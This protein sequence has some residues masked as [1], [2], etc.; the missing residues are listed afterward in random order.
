MAEGVR[1]S[2]LLL[3]LCCSSNAQQSTGIAP[4]PF[5][6]DECD[7]IAEGSICLYNGRKVLMA[8]ATPKGLVGHWNF[9]EAKVLDSSGSGNHAKNAIPAGPGYGGH[10]SSAMFN[11]FDW[12]EIPHSPSFNSPTYSITFW[13]FLYK[14][15]AAA[16][17][18]GSQSCP[19]LHKGASNDEK[20]PSLVIDSATRGLRFVSS[21]SNTQAPDGE[22]VAAFARVPV[23]RWTHIAV[24]REEQKSTIYVNGVLDAASGSVGK[25]SLNTGPLFVGGVPWLKEK[26]HLSSYV[27]SLRVYSREVTAEEVQAE[28]APALGGIEPSFVRLGCLSCSLTEAGQKCPAGYHLCS[29]M[30][31][32]TGGYQVARIQGY[33]NWD[34]HLWTS[35]QLAKL[36]SQPAGAAAAELAFAAVTPE[37]QKLGL[38][39]CC[40]DL[41]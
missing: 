41:K 19:I 15:P 18:H 6:K 20:S 9:D 7:I 25:T 32:H 36:E 8:E 16:I 1:V 24:V 23:G 14:D 11:G 34:S 37:S 5:R 10:G 33:A 2:L 28:A 21:T 35:G 30:E 22:D 29:S 4:G 26:C 39:L 38:G 13:L 3:L 40:N 12:V 17:R 27:D 31:L